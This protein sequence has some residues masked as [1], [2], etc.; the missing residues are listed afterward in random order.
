ML[1]IF[2]EGRDC[3]ICRERGE[4]TFH[5]LLFDKRTGHSTAIDMK[6]RYPENAII[7]NDIDGGLPM[8]LNSLRRDG[9]VIIATY[10][11]SQVEEILKNNA[12]NISA[13]MASQLKTLVEKMKQNEMLVMVVR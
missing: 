1:L 8:P 3:P 5:C 11:K 12:G 6:S 9:D 7:E 2:T 4:L 13:E 10:T